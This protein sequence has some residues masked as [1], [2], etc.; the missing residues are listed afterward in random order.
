MEIPD[1][2]A[3]VAMYDVD[4]LVLRMSCVIL[5]IKNGENKEVF[6][7]EFWLF[8]KDELL[9]NMGTRE[10]ILVMI[11]S[12]TGERL[13]RAM[14]GIR[15]AENKIDEWIKKTKEFPNCVLA[16][17]DFLF[18]IDFCSCGKNTDRCLTYQDYILMERD[19]ESHLP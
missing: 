1:Y 3:Y 17:S 10:D 16:R 4:D 18:D 11:G 13:K 5:K 7:E 6:R 2:T 14:R 8:D 19:K 15:R 9:V 12:L